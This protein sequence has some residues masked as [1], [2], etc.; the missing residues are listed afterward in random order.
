MRS[1]NQESINEAALQKAAAFLHLVFLRIGR[2][3]AEG[4]AL[5]RALG[6]SSEKSFAKA[7][8]DFVVTEE[9]LGRLHAQLQAKLGDLSFLS[10][11]RR[12]LDFPENP[13][14]N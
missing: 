3:S 11:R 10:K 14:V 9:Y 12:E 4:C 2:D 1:D 7:A 5:R 6:F 8:D 13:E